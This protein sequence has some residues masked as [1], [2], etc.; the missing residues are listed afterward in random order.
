MAFVAAQGPSAE[1]LSL[2][3]SR[4]LHIMYIP[5]DTL[6]ADQIKRVRTFHV[7]ADREIRPLAPVY[8]N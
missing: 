4:G 3:A 1:M 5:L 2:A 7:L 8:I 6:S